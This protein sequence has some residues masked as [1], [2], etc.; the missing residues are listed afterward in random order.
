MDDGLKQGFS[1]V[2]SQLSIVSFSHISNLYLKISINTAVKFF[3][4]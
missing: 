4:I 1:I 2:Y 3:D